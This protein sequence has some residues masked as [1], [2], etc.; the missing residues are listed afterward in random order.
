MEKKMETTGTIWGY[1]RVILGLLGSAVLK[2]AI[3][4]DLK[5]TS[6]TLHFEPST[7]RSESYKS[8]TLS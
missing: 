5:A 8:S 3:S 6:Q 1:I 2:G 7:L 4:P